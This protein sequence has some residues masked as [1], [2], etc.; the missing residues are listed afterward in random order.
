MGERD[1]VGSAREAGHCLRRELLQEIQA[2]IPRVARPILEK[3][4]SWEEF[5]TSALNGCTK[6]FP[7]P[8]V[9][10][11]GGAVTACARSLL[12]APWAGGLCQP[13]TAAATRVT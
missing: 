7:L 10:K 5:K 1:Q 11:G 8:Y 12:A 9:K 3:K 4:G 2:L 13:G 6:E